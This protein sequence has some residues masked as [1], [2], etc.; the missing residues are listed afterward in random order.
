[1]EHRAHERKPMIRDVVLFHRRQ[2]FVS[3]IL[4]TGYGP[5]H[6]RIRDL[7]MGGMYVETSLASENLSIDERLF[8]VFTSTL[9]GNRAE[10]KINL[11]VVRI[12]NAGVGLKFDEAGE[13]SL[14]SIEAL[15]H[16]YSHL[17]GASQVFHRER[18]DMIKATPLFGNLD[19]DQV[20]VFANYVRSYRANAGTLIFREGERGSYMCL[21]V[22]GNVA[23]LKEGPDAGRRLVAEV[24]AGETLGEM[25]VVDGQARSAT[26]IANTDVTLLVLTRDNFQRILTD[27]PI[28]GVEIQSR[29]LQLLSKRL[30]RTSTAFAE[31]A[32]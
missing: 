5:V 23:I 28:L 27:Q 12:D 22:D 18:C 31:H 24:G 29:L 19:P 17:S 3:V 16:G 8:A 21:I 1:M 11:S 26:C 30:R 13:E 7:S 2:N 4:Q 9:R 32:A 25:A 14:E 6:G 10:H 20:Q 15:V